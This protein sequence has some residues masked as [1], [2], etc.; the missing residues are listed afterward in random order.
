[1]LKSSSG[2]QDVLLITIAGLELRQL[3]LLVAA[4]WVP[5]PAVA[6]DGNVVASVCEALSPCWA[7]GSHLGRQSLKGLSCR[8]GA[9]REKRLCTCC[10]G[11]RLKNA[12]GRSYRT[13]AEMF[14][15]SCTTYE[16][17]LY[18]VLQLNCPAR[19]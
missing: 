1:M 18:V 17:A 10:T 15:L 3:G 5:G 13:V 6:S 14:Q 2:V 7:A 16:Q 4:P 11:V 9:N 12:G 8:D 19:P